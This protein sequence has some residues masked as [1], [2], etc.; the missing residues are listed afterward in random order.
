[1]PIAKA[2]IGGREALSEKS[3]AV[4]STVPSPPR[5]MQKSGISACC[6]TFLTIRNLGSLQAASCCL[7]PVLPSAPSV[8]QKSGI[9]ACCKPLQTSADVC[10]PA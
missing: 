1:M 2:S 6:H 8:M 5:V 10:H 3:D 4:C 7:R 9:S